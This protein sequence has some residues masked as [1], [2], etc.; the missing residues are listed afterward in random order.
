MSDPIPPRPDLPSRRD[1]APA[2]Q[3]IPRATW[4]W[5]EAIVVG[6]MGFVGGGVI[7]AILAA[8][9]GSNQVKL[10]LL[11]LGTDVGLAGA[12]A[13]WLYTNHRAAIPALRLDVHRPKELLYGVGGGLAIYAIAVLGIGPLIVEALQA[14]SGRSSVR[15]PRQIPAHLHG[16]GLVLTALFTLV[17][18]PVA[19]ELFFRGFLF[20][21]LRDRH[22]FVFSGIISALAFGAV[23]YRPSPWQDSILLIVVICFVGFGLAYVYERRGNLLANMAAHATFNAIGFALILSKQA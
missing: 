17:T 22:G 12:V 18:A 10:A 1:D 2:G 6:L 5:Y 20:R 21:S 8:P 14:I 3:G 7:G 13:L 4:R 16:A 11:G 15:T 19:E 9:F 23:H